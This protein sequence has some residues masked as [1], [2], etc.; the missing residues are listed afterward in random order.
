[1]IDL[2]H[3]LRMQNTTSNYIT[4]GLFQSRRFNLFLHERVAQTPA[5]KEVTASIPYMQGVVDLSNLIGNRIYENRTITYTFYRFGV[6]VSRISPNTARDYQTTIENLVMGEF[7]QRLD[8]S[9]EP[10]FHY[11]GKC[12]EVIVT[13]EYSHR[14]L[15]V[16]ITF[17]LY[18]FKIDNHME[19]ADL[20]DAFNFDLD[21][22]QDDI[23]FNVS[24]E[25]RNIL[26]YNAGQRT[27]SPVV[28]ADS[29]GITLLSDGI[30]HKILEGAFT[31][32]NLRLK[33]G[34]NEAYISGSSEISGANIAFDFRKERI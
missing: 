16:E 20:F 14:R 22:F 15:K 33:P 8:D 1:M 24:E 9:Y 11:T 19:S 3:G 28:R 25:G 31:Y 5:E 30:T 26:L 21:A 2:T 29:S 10:D 34:M 32:P 23:S 13:D 17:D 4:F 27:I 6:G 7:A 18:P 12:K